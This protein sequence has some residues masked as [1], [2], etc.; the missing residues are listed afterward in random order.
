[1]SP[2]GEGGGA[3]IEPRLEELGIELEA[4]RR[5]LT[6]YLYQ[7]LGDA[8]AADDAVQETMIRAWRHGTT[9]DDRSG[10]RSYLYRT[11]T[12]VALDMLRGEQ[13]R[14]ATTRPF[15]ASDEMD[16]FEA[17][18]AFLNRI[19]GADVGLHGDP[20]DLVI[21][22]ETVRETIAA[23]L[24]HL[25]ARQ[26]AVVILRELMQWRATEVAELLETSVASTNNALQRA[27]STLAD[28][29]ISVPDEAEFFP[30]GPATSMAEGTRGISEGTRQKESETRRVPR[31]ASAEAIVRLTQD[32]TP[33]IDIPSPVE[34]LQARR[35]A[36]ARSEMLARL[37]ALSSAD[38]ADLIGSSAKNRSAIASRLRKERRLLGVDYRGVTYFPAFQFSNGEPLPLLADVLAVLGDA[39][40]SDWEQALWFVTANEWL[41]GRSPV[42][43]LEDPDRVLA[44]AIREVEG[45]GG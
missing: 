19:G 2:V 30:A 24:Q 9:L 12:H 31:P 35:N 11:A 26:R 39:Q 40:W 44:A 36:I 7:M 41:E 43:A 34:L 29:G 3:T 25:P 22:K 5:E 4:H 18:W 20:A 13:R 17:E 28:V 14:R 27:R 6:V 16:T 33:P 42:D 23:V 8:F 38:V 45:F 1:V 37:G 15:E 32:L 10:F 21:A